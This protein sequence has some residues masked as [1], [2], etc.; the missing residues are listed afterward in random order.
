MMKGREKRKKEI[1]ARTGRLPKEGGCL[2]DAEA[3]KLTVIQNNPETRLNDDELDLIT[4]L[5]HGGMRFDKIIEKI[6]EERKYKLNMEE[7]KNTNS[8]WILKTW[9]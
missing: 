9:I 3:Q 7:R 2:T 4:D 6:M 1:M 8:K 5:K